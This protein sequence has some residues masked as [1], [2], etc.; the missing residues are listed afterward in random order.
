M[1]LE[2]LQYPLLSEQT[3]PTNTFGVRRKGVEEG[4]H[5]NFKSEPSP[6]HPSSAPDHGYN[7]TSTSKCNPPHTH[8]RYPSSVVARLFSYVLHSLRSLYGIVY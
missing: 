7:S 5:A 4:K 6:D 3:H 8:A 2:A 1:R